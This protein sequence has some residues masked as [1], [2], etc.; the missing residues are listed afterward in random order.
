MTNSK[1]NAL[2]KETNLEILKVRNIFDLQCM[3]FWYKFVNNRLPNYFRSMF[4]YNNEIYDIETRS[5]DKLHLFPTRTTGARNVLR[6][7]IPELLREYPEDLINEVKSH[8]L[9]AFVSHIKSQVIDSYS[10][11]CNE[12][13]C[14]V[15]RSD[16]DRM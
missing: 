4:T 16:N 10:F 5:H 14:Y 15:C 11:N 12:L 3:K 13:D 7:R 2:C 6:H 9:E 1:Y 8:S